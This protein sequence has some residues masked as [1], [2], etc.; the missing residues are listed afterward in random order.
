ML[1]ILIN[2]Q[3]KIL[4]LTELQD[5]TPLPYLGALTRN[6]NIKKNVGVKNL[7]SQQTSKCIIVKCTRRCIRS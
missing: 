3:I 4:K 7:D 2:T 6:L 5:P 1:Y